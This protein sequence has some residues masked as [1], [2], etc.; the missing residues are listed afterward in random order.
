M[1]R[2]ASVGERLDDAVP[3]GGP[4]ASAV[5]EDELRHAKVSSKPYEQT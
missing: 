3:S 1:R 4:L 2:V 5:D